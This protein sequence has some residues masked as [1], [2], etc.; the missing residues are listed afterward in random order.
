MTADKSELPPLLIPQA[1]DGLLDPKALSGEGVSVTIPPYESKAVGDLIQIY[2]SGTSVTNVVA[3]DEAAMEFDI[4]PGRIGLPR[5][6]IPEAVNGILH[7]GDISDAGAT[8]VIPRYQGI[9]A[10][11]TI[12]LS[13]KGLKGESTTFHDVADGGGV[14]P[15]AVVIP[16]STI[17]ATGNDGRVV[18]S[19]E[20]RDRAYNYSQRSEAVLLDVQPRGESEE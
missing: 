20:I 15:V 19:Y 16:L 3:D 5:P 6:V 9:A 2:W 17:D 4:P 11:D 1:D 7:L 8:V 12:V 13:W 14:K 18:V 10:G